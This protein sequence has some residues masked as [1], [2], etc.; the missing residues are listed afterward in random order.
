MYYLET[1]NKTR[2]VPYCSCIYIL[3]KISSKYHRDTSKEEYQICLN[4]CVVFKGTVCNN[5]MLDHVLSFKGETKKS[6]TKLLII[7][8]I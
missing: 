4:D 6:Q 8:Y 7:I 2:A 1:F 5:E 3:S